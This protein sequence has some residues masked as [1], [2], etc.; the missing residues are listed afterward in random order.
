MRWVRE[1]LKISRQSL[2]RGGSGR[3]SRHQ[4]SLRSA[5]NE[6]GQ[7]G[8][9]QLS[10]HRYASRPSRVV[11]PTPEE[12]RGPLCGECV[13][14]LRRLRV[15]GQSCLRGCSRAGGLSTRAERRRARAGARLAGAFAGIPDLHSPGCCD[16]TPLTRC[17][18]TRRGSA[19]SS[20]GQ[21]RRAG[22]L[23][24]GRW[25]AQTR[26][27]AGSRTCPTRPPSEPR[28][29]QRTPDARRPAGGFGVGRRGLGV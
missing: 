20:A 13:L 2:Q 17:G 12:T 7:G 21:A 11:P 24:V 27:R 8:C 10:L 18:P 15:P 6:A 23:A 22:A 9:C 3:V 5:S 29:G 19:G 16:P 1:G 4:A 26:T 28:P 25:A 14:T